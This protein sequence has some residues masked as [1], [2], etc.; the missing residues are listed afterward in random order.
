MGKLQSLI[1]LALASTSVLAV[2]CQNADLLAKRLISTSI[3]IDSKSGQDLYH[4]RPEDTEAFV[5]VWSANLRLIDPLL[6]KVESI[7]RI[8]RLRYL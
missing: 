1:L 5:S 2:P 7:N 3:S 6:P 4:L 8:F